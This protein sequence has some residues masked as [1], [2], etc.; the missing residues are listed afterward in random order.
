[1]NVAFNQS[2]LGAR[3]F[4]V[5]VLDTPK[6]LEQLYSKNNKSYWPYKKNDHSK[7][8]WVSIHFEY[9]M[10]PWF[11]SSRIEYDTNANPN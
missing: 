1:M 8:P 11:D 6:H 5:K 4:I 9:G 7:S 10:Q 3:G 2:I